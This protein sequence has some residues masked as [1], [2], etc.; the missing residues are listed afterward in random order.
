MTLKIA[1]LQTFVTV[2]RCGN[3]A[4]AAKQL[5]RTPSAVSMTLKGLD[6][7][8]ERPLFETDRKSTLT[9]LGRYVFEQSRIA[10]DRFGETVAAMERYARAE[11][12]SVRIAC[13]PSVATRILPQVLA[14]FLARQADVHVDVRDM[15]SESVVMAV[16][17]GDVDVGIASVHV[18]NPALEISALMHDRF[19]VVCAPG[20]PLEDRPQPLSWRDL[21]A[22]PLIANGLCD[23]IEDPAFRRIAEMSTMMVRNT[24]SLLALV[25][26][27]VGI[28]V[29][30]QLAVGDASSGVR[31]LGVRGPRLFRELYV[32]RRS[33]PSPTPATAV[34]M[35]TLRSAASDAS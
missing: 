23:L 15:D 13:V 19:G 7:H 30:P 34:F 29:L 5:H 26:A 12:G 21:E 14:R 6:A 20:H 18:G 16:D 10:L 33:G 31:F 25:A 28:T 9:P 24:T 27:G 2:A 8:F 22:F 3:L 17:R 32:L 11:A 4:D 1:T 35:E